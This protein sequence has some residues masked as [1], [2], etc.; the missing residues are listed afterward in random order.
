MRDDV[1]RDG[2]QGTAECISGRVPYEVESAA[3][4]WEVAFIV[5]D[6]MKAQ[7]WCVLDGY[8]AG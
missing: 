5:L 6:D 1:I 8:R 7:E 4:E 3:S 2:L